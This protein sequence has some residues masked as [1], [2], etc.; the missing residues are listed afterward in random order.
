MSAGVRP[1]NT[2]VEAVKEFPQPKSA[3]EIKSFLG[4]VNFYRSHIRELGILARPLTELTRTD[5]STGRTVPFQ[6]SEACQEA[7]KEIKRRLSTAPVLRPPDL[8]KPF[9]LWVDAS[10]VGFGAV[11]EQE[12][13]DGKTAPIA[14][15][16]RPTSPA[17]QKF[18]ATELEVAGLVFALEHFEVYVLGNP[19]TVYTDHQSYLP[20][21]KSQAKGI[22][23]R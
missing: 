22:L 3:Q 5:K 16:S 4:L 13:E 20:Y 9:F 11:L 17:E 14:F 2:K 15:A 23:A 10:A 18:A 6:W 1:N 7:F 19:V 12:T 21:L 8:A